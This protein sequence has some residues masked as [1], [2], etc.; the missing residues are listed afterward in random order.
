MER[1]LND[2]LFVWQYCQQLGS[3]CSVLCVPR[4]PP[5]SLKVCP[6]STGP[7]HAGVAVLSARARPP[8][9]P[10]RP[11]RYG[12]V[13]RRFDRNFRKVLS[14]LGCS[15]SILSAEKVEPE[16]NRGGLRG[17]MRQ[18]SLKRFQKKWNPAHKMEP[19]MEPLFRCNL[20]ILT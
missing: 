5:L 20:A 6:H 17:L 10:G 19:K 14:K 13:E 2:C 4:C 1:F 16:W 3:T 9:R 11:R 15:G 7:G 8:A 18:V 12:F